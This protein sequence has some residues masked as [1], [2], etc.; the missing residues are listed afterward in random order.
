MTGGGKNQGA[1]RRSAALACLVSLLLC[2]CVL[3]A[4]ADGSRRAAKG[5]VGGKAAALA[6]LEAA[7]YPEDGYLP[8]EVV[9]VLERPSI[10]V[11]E[12][13]CGDFAGMLA[14]EQSAAAA[15]IA[16]TPAAT[17]VRLRLLPGVDELE[18][19]RRL[20]SSP[21]V[22]LAEPNIIFR[23]AETVPNDPLYVPNDPLYTQQ[24]NLRGEY[25]VRASEAWDVSRGSAGLTLAVVDTGIDCTHPDLKGR[26][27][28]GYDYYNGD[29]DPWDDNG[30]GT[31][32][33]GMACANT[34]N[35]TGVA[36]LDWHA[37]VM[38][39]KAL[40]AEGEGYLDSVVNSVKH[41]ANYGAD[42]INMSL[43]SDTYSQALADAA[44]YAHS[45]GC[46]LVAA[47]GNE[48]DERVNY[49]AG[50]PHVIGVGSTDQAGNR[51]LFSNHNPSVDMVAPGERIIGP[52]PG[53][54]YERGW[55]TSEATPHVSGAALLLLAQDPS[56][57][58]DEIWRRLENGARDLGAPGYD[59]Y[60]GWGLL[61]VNASLRTPLVTIT[62][63]QEYSYPDTGRVSASAQAIGATITDLELWVN[64][65][66][67]ESCALPVPGSSVSHVFDYYDLSGLRTGA[68]EITVRAVASG[69][70]YSTYGEDT[71]TVYRNDSQPRPSTDW[72]LAEGTTAWGFEEYVL[73]QNPNPDPCSLQVTFM[74]PGGDTEEH[75]FTMPGRS[76]L[77][78]NVN[79]LVASSDVSTHVHADRPVVA[80]RAMYWGGRDVGHATMG[81]T[82]GCFTWYLAEGTTAWGFEEYVLVQNPNPSTVNLNFDFRKP[83]GGR[84]YLAHSVPPLSRYTLN[85]AEV[86]PGSDVSAF[87][88]ADL[89]VIVERAMYWPRDSRTRAGAH[90]SVGS[91]TAA[92]TWYLAEGT[93]AWGFDEY[94]L[95]ANL[96][97]E[98][99]HVDLVFM[100]PDGSNTEYG[101]EV[102]PRA[103]YTVFANE[104][105][106]DRD[107][108]VFVQSDRP[109]V[110]ERAMYWSDKEG[111][112]GVLGVL[113][114]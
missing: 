30:H 89:P 62:S 42:V 40:G 56:A 58:P 107:A 7:N 2:S 17:A 48:G 71:V 78:L 114:P 75:R 52:V 38:P 104:M 109:L 47:A 108:S 102:G 23:A 66:L 53:G 41:A 35:S 81:V 11:L 95:L 54:G 86:V 50:L 79:S 110:V 34:D 29:Y 22:R 90:C 94:V 33:A 1:S 51:S 8:G 46:V 24:W 16:G 93:T 98:F 9:V 106:P 55:G 72:Y 63:P 27:S 60:Y 3:A 25:G 88:E 28:G 19:A 18:A 73:V 6:R 32:V 5:G 31:M 96:S 14:K 20:L 111:G 97:D 44:E 113:E 13:L 100:G 82:E 26:C 49:P 61:D 101:V 45:R 92:G 36:G 69:S 68:S 76:R 21:L 67:E 10:E 37:R 83:D 112:T 64:G 84:S 43:T 80:E 99:A 70:S 57:T 15:R 85:V 59:E 4:Q 87:I 91:M 65:E 103:R 12:E 77:T 39:L 105:D 74:K